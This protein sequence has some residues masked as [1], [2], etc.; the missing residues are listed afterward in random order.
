M[1][2]HVQAS[3]EEAGISEDTVPSLSHAM[4]MLI[5]CVD[6]QFVLI[7]LKSD[8]SHSFDL[9][10]CRMFDLLIIWFVFFVC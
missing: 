3:P 7:C 1:A 9:L 5:I 10:I 8:P 6:L 2:P 4:I